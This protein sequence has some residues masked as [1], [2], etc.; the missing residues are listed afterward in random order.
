MFF[1]KYFLLFLIYSFI[2]WIVEVT[3]V[4][5]MQKVLV[6][7]GFLFGPCLPIYGFGS[8]LYLFLLNKY[9]EY[10]LIIFTLGVVISFILE[11]V[12]SYVLELLFN[13]KWWDYQNE[14]YNISGRVCLKT[15]LPFGLFSILCI[16]IINPALIFVLSIIK[17]NIKIT[18]FILFLFLYIVDSVTSTIINIKIKKIKFKYDK[19][20]VVKKIIN[21]NK[22][23]DKKIKY[24]RYN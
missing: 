12:T 16:Y 5:K 8:L 19:N 15:L 21:T 10:P 7:R 17:T 9:Y 6:N 20:I 13:E 18:I 1:I 2:G 3:Y 23:M 11:Y 4:Y 22:S 14:K 24:K